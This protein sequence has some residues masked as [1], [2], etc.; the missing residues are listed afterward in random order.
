MPTKR[1]FYEVLEISRTSN[2]GEI[3]SAYRKLVLQYHP[4][5]NA[6]DPAAEVRFKEVQEA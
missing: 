6:H 2:D 5:R 1:C 3:K 4:D